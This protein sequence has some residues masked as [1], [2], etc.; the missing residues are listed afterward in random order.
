MATNIPSLAE[1]KMLRLKQVA[2]RIGLSK[3]SI[4][5]RIQEG[6]FPAPVAL[7]K[8]AVG[9]DSTEI[10]AWIEERLAEAHR[11]RGTVDTRRDRYGSQASPA[12]G[13]R[14]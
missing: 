9:W 3:S 1:R 5:Q 12:K 11:L 14:S 2:S 7:G 10:D 13:V 6:S 8:R 4:Y